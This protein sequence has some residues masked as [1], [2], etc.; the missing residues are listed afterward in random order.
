M[1]R[2][3]VLAALAGGCLLFGLGVAAVALPERGQGGPKPPIPYPQKI[4]LLDVNFLFKNHAG[5]K[6]MKEEMQKDVRRAEEHVKREKGE[7]AAL[8]ARLKEVGPGTSEQ[9]STEEQIQERTAL[10]NIDITRQR[11]A[12]LQQEAEI[13]LKVHRR[14]Q[15]EVRR[16][17]KD[18][19]IT[20]VLKF[21]SEP[22][23][24]NVPE[25]IVRSINN[26]VVYCEEGL[27][28]TPIILNRVNEKNSK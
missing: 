6:A 3:G 2:S 7:I 20:A 24:P 27:D 23:N 5:L 19:Q 15:Q 16:Y 9:K 14:I 26:S 13:Y 4:A 18:N 8:Q 25:T 21:D 1:S 28:I 12:F 10:L 22:V 17:A 11:K